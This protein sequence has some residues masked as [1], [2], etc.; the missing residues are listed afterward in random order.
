[1]TLEWRLERSS[2]WMTPGLPVLI[3]TK[4]SSLHAGSRAILSHVKKTR[5]LSQSLLT[6]QHM[7]LF[8]WMGSHLQKVGIWLGLQWIKVRSVTILTEKIG[9]NWWSS[10]YRRYMTPLT[11]G[12]ISCHTTRKGW[13][14][15]IG[16]HS[17]KV[18]TWLQWSED[19][20][21]AILT[22]KI[23]CK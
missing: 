20:L 12:S 7:K 14:Q 2:V 6:L 15:G 19:Q 11:S 21:V 1:M 13:L 18:I 23:G 9:C 10:I 8:R 17:Q 22:E 3:V 5:F 16:S 4:T